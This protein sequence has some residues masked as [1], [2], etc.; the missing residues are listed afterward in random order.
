[1]WF[2]LSAVIE[3]RLGIEEVFGQDRREDQFVDERCNT[4]RPQGI[5]GAPTLIHKSRARSTR[6]PQCF[7]MQENLTQC[8]NQHD[9]LDC[10]IPR[11]FAF[12]GTLRKFVTRVIS[13]HPDLGQ[14]IP[15]SVPMEDQF[16]F[17]RRLEGLAP[18]R[19]YEAL[20]FVVWRADRDCIPGG[21]QTLNRV[22]AA[23]QCRLA[24]DET[25][26]DI[27]F[28][29]DGLGIGR[30]ARQQQAQAEKNEQL[31]FHI[32]SSCGDGETRAGSACLVNAYC[33]QFRCLPPL[34]IAMVLITIATIK[35]CR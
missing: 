30:G 5:P 34:H 13:G 19:Q 31:L 1:M 11:H 33:F 15:I 35:Q 3:I 2:S 9:F 16:G 22:L 6:A 12:P 21:S 32:T 8:R 28:H 20:R 10:V 25:K 27:H 23:R 26:W 4:E 17:L 14:E 29:V 18:S 7:E 24:D